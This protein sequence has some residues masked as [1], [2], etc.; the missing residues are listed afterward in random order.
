V[1]VYDDLLPNVFDDDRVEV[2]GLIDEKFE[3][4]NAFGATVVQPMIQAVYVVKPTA[5]PTA[6]PKPKV[7]KPPTPTPQ[8]ANVGEQVQ[9]GNWLFTVTEVQYHKALYLHD[10]SKVAMGVYCVMFIDIQNQASGTASFGELWWELHGA[11]GKVYDDD[12]ET[13]Y[14]AWQFGGKDTPWTDVNPGQTLQIALAIDVGQEAKGLQLYS[15]KLKK[16][17]VLIGD[18]QPPQD[19]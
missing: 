9:A 8:L 17:F 10:N 7:T 4:T 14:A 2:C 11:G 5:K 19:Q 15:Y 12:S 16:P 6:K 18:A 3:G 13:F 1:V